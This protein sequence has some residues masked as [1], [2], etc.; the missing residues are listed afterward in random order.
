MEIGSCCSSL[1]SSMTFPT[2]LSYRQLNSDKSFI[3]FIKYCDGQ[4]AIRRLIKQVNQGTLPS[5]LDDLKTVN[6]ISM[7]FTTKTI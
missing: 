2:K 3:S 7:Y 1:S 6:S 4:M 5:K